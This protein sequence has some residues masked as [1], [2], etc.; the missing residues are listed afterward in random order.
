MNG[1][2]ARTHAGIGADG[3]IVVLF[4]TSCATHLEPQYLTP[5]HACS[6]F[7][8]GEVVEI[9]G[10]PATVCGETYPDGK[11]PVKFT[12]CE[13]HARVNSQYLQP[14]DTVDG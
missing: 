5:F 1:Q 2:M 3:K 11:V 10:L 13:W 8:G 14:V 7:Y 4:G 9:N 12:G 6:K